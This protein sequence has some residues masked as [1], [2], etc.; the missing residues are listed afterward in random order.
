LARHNE[1]PGRTVAGASSVRGAGRIEITA[2][3]ADDGGQGLTRFGPIGQGLSRPDAVDISGRVKTGDH[4]FAHGLIL[5][6]RNDLAALQA[7]QSR[8]RDDQGRGNS[9]QGL[10]PG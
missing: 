2:H 10:S 6:D 1:G 5:G 4:A 9:K 7:G 8:D 3:R